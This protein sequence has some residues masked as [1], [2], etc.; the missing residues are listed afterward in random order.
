MSDFSCDKLFCQTTHLTLK[1]QL[2][3]KNFV[4]KSTWPCVEDRVSQEGGQ[5]IESHTGLYFSGSKS[6]YDL[7]VAYLS[8]TR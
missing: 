4:S 7:R 8:Y 5:G 2:F 1:G 3:E 6:R